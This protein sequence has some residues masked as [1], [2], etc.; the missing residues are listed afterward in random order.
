MPRNGI[1]ECGVVFRSGHKAP[2]IVCFFP[3]GVK[4]VFWY[5]AGSL[6]LTAPG[7]KEGAGGRT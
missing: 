5:W 4:R 7:E 2:P 1:H 6:G 3:T